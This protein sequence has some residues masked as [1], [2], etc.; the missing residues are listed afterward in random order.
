MSKTVWGKEKEK[1]PAEFS[2]GNSSWVVL[3]S[4]VHPDPRCCFYRWFPSETT[5]QNR[6]ALGRLSPAHLLRRSQ[7]TVS[8]GSLCP[9]REA[10]SGHLRAYC[11]WHPP[12]SGKAA[13]GPRGG[14]LLPQGEELDVEA[15]GAYMVGSRLLGGGPWGRVGPSDWGSSPHP[16]GEALRLR[17]SAQRVSTPR[18]W[19]APAELGDRLWAVGVFTACSWECSEHHSHALQ[20]GVYRFLPYSPASERLDAGRATS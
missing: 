10:A 19:A 1:E 5:P 17:P 2:G 3:A 11:V 8:E 14:V 16:S 18:P 12:V 20:W 4:L 6:S 7:R 9:G 15:Q 13:V